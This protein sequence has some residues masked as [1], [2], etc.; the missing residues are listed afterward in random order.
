MKK[1]CLL[2]LILSAPV[3]VA[4]SKGFITWV[5][6]VLLDDVKFGQCLARVR[7]IAIPERLP[8]CKADYVTFDCAANPWSSKSVNSKKFDMA[9]IALIAKRDVAFLITDEKTINGYCYVT[10]ARLFDT[11]WRHVESSGF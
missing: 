3:S 7:G 2:L 8:L 11:R 5:R 1:L 9:N 4:D 6:E 10:Q